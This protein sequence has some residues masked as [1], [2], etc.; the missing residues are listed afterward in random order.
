M[1]RL[2]IT[3]L[4]G[5]VGGA[6]F[7]R[8]LC[9]RV[10]PGSITVIGNTGDDEEFF[11]LHV[12]PDLDTVVYTLAGRVDPRRGWGIRGDSFRCLR[13][14][15]ALGGPTWFRLGDRDL[16]TH[17]L[18]TAWL[19]AGWP[20][21]R[22]TATLARVHRVDA[23]VLPVTDDRLRTFVHTERGRLPFQTYLVRHGGHGR[24]R[25]IEVAGAGRTHPAPGVLAAL[26]DTDAIVVAPSNP[27]VS[28]G[29]M[30]AVPGVRASLA[31]RRVPAAAVSPLVGG[32][33]VRGPLVTMLRG[34]GHE[35]SPRGIARLY[36][37]L[38]DVF[39]FDRVDA[40]WAPHVEALG[41]R[42]LVTDT[43][44]RTPAHA[45]RLAAAVVRAL[46][47]GPTARMRTAPDRADGV[48]R[49]A[50]RASRA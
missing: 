6:R 29:P 22:V 26:R 1:S 14:L 10:D 2:R 24:V 37:G 21:S 43:I 7:L 42:P 49:P 16:A 33:A 35:V 32:R 44:M 18:R 12:A 3:V 46:Q 36:R 25:R 8:G 40:A 19:R 20:L 15:G 31:A 5:G 13:A 28:I 45:S 27:L 39:V 4:A 47:A 17:L 9:R 48:P 23:R 34:L 50:R 41:L 30:L 11:G 38:V